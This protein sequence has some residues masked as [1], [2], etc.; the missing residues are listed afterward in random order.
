MRVS[1]FIGILVFL[2]LTVSSASAVTEYIL[3]EDDTN[4]NRDA[5]NRGFDPVLPEGIL[6]IRV[7]YDETAG[8][9]TYVDE[10]PHD[11]NGEANPYILRPKIDK[12]AHNLPVSGGITAF[13]E[14]DDLNIGSSWVE[15]F[16]YGVSGFETF[17]RFYT[18]A[19]SERPDK[20]I[21]TLNPTTFPST[22]PLNDDQK[23]VELHIAF[24]AF[25]ADGS[26]IYEIDEETGVI[27]NKDLG[28][29]YLAS[30]T[31][32]PEFPSIVLPVAAIMGIL[33]I[34]QNRRKER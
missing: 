13:K 24:E 34:S 21:V 10:S 22:I 20:V 11:S 19:G 9:I 31:E 25:Y 26:P 27:I 32:I 29:T 16:D 3:T 14:D 7:I 15:H 4:V 30:G 2:L 33:L 5:L 6:K 1:Y 17:A 12:V 8:T 28:S 23:A 18:Y